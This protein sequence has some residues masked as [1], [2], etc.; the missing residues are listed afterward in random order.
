MEQ[1]PSILIEIAKRENVQASAIEAEIKES[2]K[3]DKMATS[4]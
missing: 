2:E 4:T 3:K 1:V